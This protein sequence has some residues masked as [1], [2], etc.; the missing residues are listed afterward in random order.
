MIKFPPFTAKRGRPK[1]AE[2]TVIGMPA[3]KK[4]YRQASNGKPVPFIQKQP[5][6]KFEIMLCWLLSKEDVKKAMEG[7]LMDKNSVE[8]CPEKVHPS[9]IDDAIN[10]GSIQAF[11]TK[12]AWMLVNQVI[13]KVKLAPNWTCTVCKERVEEECISCDSCLNCYH[14]QCASLK[15][16][17]KSRFWFCNNCNSKCLSI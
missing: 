5:N 7:S 1:G 3:K 11:F 6:E 4:K 14:F 8:V 15:K 2:L 16:S 12:E 9:I 10:V 17:P 13:D